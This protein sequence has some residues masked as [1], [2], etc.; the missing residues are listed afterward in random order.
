MVI[1]HSIPEANSWKIS[2][3]LDQNPPGLAPRPLLRRPAARAARVELRQV[4]AL[5]AL[6]RAAAGA[7]ACAVAVGSENSWEI[8]G[9]N[10]D[11]PGKN[12]EKHVKKTWKNHG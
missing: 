4:A 1:V 7:G 10:A 2:H 8:Y 3:K 5:L 6:R 11:V 12:R 9:G